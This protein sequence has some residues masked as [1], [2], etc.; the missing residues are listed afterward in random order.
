MSG[1]SLLVGRF[2]RLSVKG[3]QRSPLLQVCGVLS[4]PAVTDPNARCNNVRWFSARPSQASAQPTIVTGKDGN[5]YAVLNKARMPK[6]KPSIVRKRIEELKTYEGKEKGIRHSPWRLNLI[7]QFAAGQPLLEALKQLEF[8]E[9]R[10]APLIQKILT[11]TANLADIRDGLQPS[12]LEVAE[13]FA[14]NGY[15]LKRAKM[16]GRGRY[17]ISSLAIS[18]LN[19]VLER[20]TTPLLRWKS[21]V[22]GMLLIK[23]MILTRF[24]SLCLICFSSQYR[25]GIMHHRFSHLRVVLREIDFPLKIYQAKTIG[26]KQKWIGLQLTAQ[27]DA[28][29]AQAERDELMELERQVAE[30]RDKE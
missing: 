3:K 11:R 26:Q 2:A 22:P 12:Q 29:R 19:S 5:Q 17:V 24:P 14:T 13:C 21:L 28:D 8:C 6:L 9:K 15:H 16:M 30:S 1:A 20:S 27:E 7:C 25:T 4:E 23:T 18:Q 10:K